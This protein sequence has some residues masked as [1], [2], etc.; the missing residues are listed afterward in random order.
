[1]NQDEQLLADIPEFLSIS[2]ML[3]ATPS[4][5]GG[6]RFI[7]LEASNEGVDQQGERVLAKALEDSASHFLKF[8]NIDLDHFTIIGQRMGLANPMAYEVGRPVDVTV[9][10]DRTFVKAQLYKGTG[11]LAKN[12]NMVWESMTQL[13]PPARWYPSVGGSVLA[14]SV[15]LDPATNEK[16]GLVTKVRWTNI[17]LSRTPVNQ[18][19][20]AAGTVPL[21]TFAKSL[22]GLVMSKSLTAGY[23]S[24]MA[25][26]SGGAAIRMQS[27]DGV[28]Q[29]YYEFRD[30]ISGAVSSREA[31]NQSRNGLIAYSTQKFNLSAEEAAEW[32]DRFLSD[33][34]KHQSNR[35]NP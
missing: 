19:L 6:E 23:G 33:L 21:A 34:K 28:P 20:P 32:V 26:L 15:Q 7:Y 22:G 2:E 11:E 1:M 5:E 10:G 9:R 8:G 35:S 4:E 16:V 13:N 27:L 24:D 3:K 14:K 18:H 29:S 12:A 17:A 31:N 25:N 30:E